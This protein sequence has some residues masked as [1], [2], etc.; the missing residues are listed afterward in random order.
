MKNK[1]QTVGMDV[2]CELASTIVE[3]QWNKEHYPK[4]HSYVDEQG[5]IRYIEEVQDEFNVVLDIVDDILNPE[6]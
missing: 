5:D 1:V 4:E 2:L 6:V 3:R